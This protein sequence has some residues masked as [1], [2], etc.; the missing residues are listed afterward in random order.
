[1][2]SSEKNIE[3][4]ELAELGRGEAPSERPAA[5]DASDDELE[6]PED[7]LGTARRLWEAARGQRWRL[8]VAAVCSVLYVAGSLGATAYSAG[9]IDLLWNNIQA[10]FEAGAP[11][12]VTLEN[13][14]VQI[15]TFLGIWT[16]AWGAYTV[17]VLV[18]ASF[19]E[20][21]N[22]G[23]RRRIGEKL[24]RLP[25]AYYDAHQPGDTISRATNDLDKVSEVLQRGLLQLLIAV[26]MVGGAVIL[27]ATYDLALTGVFVV[28][29]LV[30]SVATKLV[31]ARTLKVAAARQ[32]A[33]GDLTGRVE[34]AY[35][36]R[37]VIK[38]FGREDASL[39]EVAEAAERL[40]E[41][42][43]T[44]DFVT[45]A[46]APAIRLLM[47]LCQVTIG[48]L[49]GGMLV[50][51]QIS[52]GVFQA[53]FQYVMQ[54]SE[55][56]TQLALTVNM[57]QG[58][59]A[60]AERVF[61]F[62]DEDEVVP[63][64]ASPAELPEAVEGRVAFEHV[65][66]GYA[67]DRPLMRDVSLVAEPGQKV[68]IVG[69]TGAGKTTLINLLMRFYEVD[70]GR[71]TLD[72][73][74]TR[75]LTRAE[76]RRQFGM[77]LQD[78]WLFEGTIAENIAY[79]KPGAT[80]E[81]VEAAARAAH[82]D[83]FVRTLPHGY[84][85]MLSND[86]EN[87]SQGQRQLLTIARAMLTDPAILILDEATSSVDTRTEQAIVRAMEAIM[88]NRTSFVIAHRL[89]TVVD[90]DLILVME[91][92]TIIEQGTHAELLAADGAYAELYRSQFA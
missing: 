66:F 47:R 36:G 24:S 62:L 70:G 85:T 58:A 71:I 17:Q 32:A 38:A 48:L 6:V 46:I 15:L 45:N 87:I 51:G 88:E 56:F 76:L 28:F 42:S 4:D 50:M 21:L 89:S 59:L 60:A 9:L 67:P 10:T 81:E 84:D 57:L 74:D 18:M 65:R 69:A 29:G 19:A 86:A 35:S 54:A 64:P 52:V 2:P 34:E 3:L 43:A 68:A 73:V 20:R 90:A 27:M 92:G 14:G 12:V 55:P 80:R 77:V 5:P 61:A 8:V 25:L 23:L 39:A 91:R 11:F 22:L 82:V 44:A 49:A 40:A 7:A 30:A 63:D 79:G 72:G 31:T 16:A 26:C 78:A 13:G 83:F 41:T 75:D 37:A 33:L 53:F 1:M